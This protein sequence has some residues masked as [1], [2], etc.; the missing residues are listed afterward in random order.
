MGYEYISKSRMISY[1]NQVRVIQSLGKQ[2][3]SILE[4]GIFNNICS[5]LLRKN[6]YLVTT[7]DF[8]KE[9][10]PDIILDLNSD[11]EIPQDKFDAI[12]CFQ[13]LEHIPYEASEKALKKLVDASRKYVV[14]SL[15]YYSNFVC[16]RLT[17]SW[18]WLPR[19]LMLQ[20][21]CF[22]KTEPKCPEHYWELGMK[23]YPKKRFLE[24]LKKLDL[25][26]KRDY[27]DP[28]NPYHWFF[29]IEKKS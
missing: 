6:G 14:I 18:S 1:Y 23:G 7:A 2:V 13:V 27:Q 10:N 26:L 22:W 16:L 28:L 19:H 25:H 29:V 9:L 21:P 12:A 20:I 15:P 11:F 24:T 17:I 5:D 8:N 3:Q 4:I